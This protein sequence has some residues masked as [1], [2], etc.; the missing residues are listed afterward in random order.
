MCG[1]VVGEGGWKTHAKVDS[2]IASTLVKLEY[3]HIS[4]VTG[5][6]SGGVRDMKPRRQGP[7]TVFLDQTPANGKLPTIRGHRPNL[8][9]RGGD[10]Q[11]KC[12][13]P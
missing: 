3:H 10:S 6:R 2:C 1:G 7:A 4:L 11:K 5:I 8:R 9:Y 13:N 12:K